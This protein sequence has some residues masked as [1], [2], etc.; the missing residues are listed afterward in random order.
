MLSEISQ[1]EKDNTIQ[2]HLYVESNEQTELTRKMGTDSQME[3]RLTASWGV[4]VRGQRDGA[5][6]KKD[7]WSWTTVW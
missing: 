5:E 3:S 7:S 6:R 4:G 2:S 1:S